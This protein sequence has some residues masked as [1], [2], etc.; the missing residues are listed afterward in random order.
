MLPIPAVASVIYTLGQAILHGKK[1]HTRIPRSIS[2]SITESRDH[3][4]DNEDGVGRMHGD[5]NVGE[6]VA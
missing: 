2:E 5:D 6:E 1:I 3:K 4:D